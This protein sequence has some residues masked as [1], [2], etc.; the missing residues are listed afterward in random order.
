MCLGVY[1]ISDQ[2]LPAVA[3][4]ESRPVF[5]VEKVADPH[6]TWRFGPRFFYKAFCHMGCGCGFAACRWTSNEETGEYEVDDPAENHASRRGLADF[7]SA[8]LRHQAAVEVL[9]G[10]GGGSCELERPLPRRRA[11]PADF[12]RDYAL[13][14]VMGQVVVVSEADA[15]AHGVELSADS[16]ADPHAGHGGVAHAD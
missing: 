13:F 10:Y 2:E 11:R 5:H 15:G 7:L 16:P 14:D 3:R 9:I 6:L 1:I 12:T 8:A 4:D